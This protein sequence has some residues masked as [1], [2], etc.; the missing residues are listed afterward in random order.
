MFLKPDD[1][2]GPLVSISAT[3]RRFSF[4]VLVA[5][6][7]GCGSP[8]PIDY[9]CR[10]AELSAVR[11]AK[12]APALG[13]LGVA[14]S[15]VS[16]YVDANEAFAARVC[17]SPDD[18]IAD[19]AETVAVRASF[20]AMA[21]D[22][23]T[24]FSVDQLSTESVLALFLAEEIEEYE[25]ACGPGAAGEL[26]Q[27]DRAI[28]E[29]A[30]QQEES[31]SCGSSSYDQPA[32][33]GGLD[34]AGGGKFALQNCIDNMIEQ[35]IADS[36]CGPD[37]ASEGEGGTDGGSETTDPDEPC[38]GEDYCEKSH[39][40]DDEYT[41]TVY[42]RN[43]DGTWT[44]ETYVQKLDDEG[45]VTEETWTVDAGDGSDP[46]TITLKPNE[47]LVGDEAVKASTAREIDQAIKEIEDK[48]YAFMGVGA[49]AAVIAAVNP[50]VGA[51]LGAA[52]AVEYF[53]LESL[54]RR[55]KAQREN[56]LCVGFQTTETTMV[57]YAV[58]PEFSGY[59]EEGVPNI[60]G[61][62]EYCVC[63][64][65]GSSDGLPG[66]QCEAER[67]EEERMECLANPWG[68][69]DGP[70]PE[71][72]QHMRTDNL[73]LA[74]SDL[75]P[76]VTCP[77]ED[78]T[79][80]AFPGLPEPESPDGPGC[81]CLDADVIPFRPL[82]DACTEMQCADGV[83]CLCTDLGVCG[84]YSNDG[85]VI[86]GDGTPRFGPIGPPGDFP[87]PGDDPPFPN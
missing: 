23:N 40:T 55:L 63:Q 73:D 7:A 79:A 9:T 22:L 54:K 62:I 51:A 42:R 84:C 33:L 82:G 4:W 15:L 52:A 87:V 86:D 10:S 71:C 29:G 45:N 57:S 60:M 68:P 67:E 35:A 2:G 75:C 65:S 83:P 27:P 16:D 38:G 8:D 11:I 32:D 17:T 76:L 74:D 47:V 44:K 70:R 28:F 48:Q 6:L 66:F 72:L 34:S 20:D 43:E 50:P 1:R 78:W 39:L 59:G 41:S 19:F 36:Q 30:L 3:L 69:D 31:S 18:P 21:S 58:G 64:H 77:A 26:G 37:Q 12:L 49:A 80:A 46:Q 85:I 81:G 56:L 5:I 61:A 53:W 13:Y 25:D 24:E 14:S